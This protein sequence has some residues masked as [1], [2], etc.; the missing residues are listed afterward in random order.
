MRYRFI[1]DSHTHSECSFDGTDSVIMMC[2]QASGIGLYS[3]AVTDHCEC[4]EFYEKNVREDISRSIFQI[5]KARA[6]YHDRLKVF[7]GIELGQPTQDVEAAR[8]ALSMAGY[9][10]VLGSLHNLRGEQDF[11]FLDY[12]EETAREYLDRYLDELLEL[13]SQNLFD[14]LAHID[15]PLRYMTGNAGIMPDKKLYAE[16]LD[17]VLEMLVKNDRAIE[18]NTSGLRQVIGRTLPGAE[19]I[20]RFRELG[21]KYVTLGSDAHRWGDIGSGIETGLD[22]LSSCGFTH[23]TI[24]EKREPRLLPIL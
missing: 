16:K 1:S 24:Y 5:S 15:Y 21:G 19:I 7:C 14:C 22:M 11:Y 6:M 13:V 10:F 8:E 20:K 18:I 4:N 23:F 9:D 2:E 17:A 12:S 3:M